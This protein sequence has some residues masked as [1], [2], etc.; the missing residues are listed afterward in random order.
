[1]KNPKQLERYFKGLANHWRIS[2]LL[3]L[4]KQTDLSLTVIAD[5][6]HGNIFTISEHVNRLRHA[7]LINKQYRGR[8]VLHSLSPYGKIFIAFL[9][10]AKKL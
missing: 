6:V 4:D 1:M 2:I 9:K 10:T 8:E 3:L 7:G 5:Q